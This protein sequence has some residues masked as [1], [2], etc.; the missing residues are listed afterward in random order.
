[1]QK[2]MQA[3]S[4]DRPLSWPRMPAPRSPDA[5]YQTHDRR[6][7]APVTGR[8]QGKVAFITGLAR[9]QG[10]AH[11]IKLASEGA[12]IVGLDICAQIDTVDYPMS[13]PDD[14]QQTVKLVE[15]AGQRI[16]ARIGDVRDAEPLK[17]VYQEGLDTFG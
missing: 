6:G 2:S 7:G 16:L 11:A 3:P 17:S 13:T 10:R 1:M 9:G 14:L 5:S 4:G 8:V 15:Q 12:D